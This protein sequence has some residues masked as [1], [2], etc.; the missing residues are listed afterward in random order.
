MGYAI[1]FVVLDLRQIDTI[2]I[3][4]ALFT[5]NHIL[6]SVARRTYLA[7]W[8]LQMCNSFLRQTDTFSLLVSKSVLR[9]VLLSLNFRICVFKILYQCVAFTYSNVNTEKK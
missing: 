6:L 7:V 8:R 1:L 5:K 4:N 9:R 2:F 3:K